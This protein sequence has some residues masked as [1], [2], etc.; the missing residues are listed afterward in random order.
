L[1]REGILIKEKMKPYQKDYNPKFEAE[2][3]EGVPGTSKAISKSAK[4][5]AENA[6]RS[7]KKAVRQ[8]AKQDIRNTFELYDNLLG[9]KSV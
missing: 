9:R 6:N 5:E 4:L 7:R 2:R 3:F 1:E 8:R